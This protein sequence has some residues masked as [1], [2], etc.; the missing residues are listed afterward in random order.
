MEDIKDRLGDYKYNF[1]TKLQKYL[2]TELYFYGSIKRFD[3]FS[4]SSDIDITVITDNIKSMMS[5]IQNYLHIPNSH[6]QTIF[7]QNSI[8]DKNIITGYKIKYKNTEDNIQ[9]DLLIY[10]EKHRKEVLQRIYYIN[11]LPFYI[12]IILCILKILYY[13]LHLL[14]KSNFVYLKNYVFFCYFNGKMGYYSKDSLKENS[15]IIML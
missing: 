6:I 13:N 2:D 12:V 5:R 10:D 14:S 11:N 4:K 8:H 7:Q 3:Y 15:S 9:F 1:F